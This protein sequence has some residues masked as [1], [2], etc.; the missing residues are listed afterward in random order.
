MMGFQAK[1]K[2]EQT[3][4]PSCLARSA[5]TGNPPFDCEMKEQNREQSLGPRR[6]VPAPEISAVEPM[7]R[8]N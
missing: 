5:E 7:V 2:L 4:T 6:V 3:H 8:A 1:G